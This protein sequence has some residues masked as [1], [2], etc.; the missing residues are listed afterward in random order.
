MN[1]VTL[2]IWQTNRHTFFIRYSHGALDGKP[3]GVV[4]LKDGVL[5]NTHETELDAKLALYTIGAVCI[6]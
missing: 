1:T 3:Y 4:R 5:I 6:G 2:S